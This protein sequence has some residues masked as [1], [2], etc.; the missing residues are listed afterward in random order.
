MLIAYLLIILSLSVII[1]A[2]SGWIFLFDPLSFLFILLVSFSLY[3]I[4]HGWTGFRYLLLVLSNFLNR[5]KLPSGAK[6]YIQHLIASIYKA[7]FIGTFIGLIILLNTYDIKDIGTQRHLA[8]AS[9]TL[10]YATILNEIFLR[11]ID[12]RLIH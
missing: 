2:N 11:P 7:G 8:D 12:H 6:P 1:T 4:S 5:K 9:L 10:F 3:Y